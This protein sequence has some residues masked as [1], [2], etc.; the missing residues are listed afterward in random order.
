[1]KFDFLMVSK[2]F[3]FMQYI[4]DPKNKLLNLKQTGANFVYNLY[5]IN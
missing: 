3:H 1:M 2:N 4:K 5:K